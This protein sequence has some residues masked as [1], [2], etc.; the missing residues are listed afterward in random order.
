MKEKR[1]IMLKER[2]ENKK[3]IQ[4]VLDK[5]ER[6]RK[7]DKDKEANTR[8]KYQELQKF[9]RVQAGEIADFDAASAQALSSIV[10]GKSRKGK[11]I[12][13]PM[14]LEEIRMNKGLLKEIAAMKK[15]Q[16]ISQGKGSTMGMS[17][18]KSDVLV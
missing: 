15:Q 10:G 2:E 3:Y 4:M 6:D 5:D 8:A 16:T 18:P 12:G 7:N 17:P 1:D 9:Q 14:N 11:N 13:G